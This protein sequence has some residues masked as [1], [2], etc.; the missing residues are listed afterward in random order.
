MSKDDFDV[1][2]IIRAIV[3]PRQWQEVDPQQRQEIEETSLAQKELSVS[4]I[5]ISDKKQKKF[6]FPGNF[7]VRL[8]GDKLICLCK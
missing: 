8:E 3:N 5:H 1:S 7:V 2:E 4:E 6:V